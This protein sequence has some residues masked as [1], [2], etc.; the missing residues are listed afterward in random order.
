MGR[1]FA[2]NSTKLR[3]FNEFIDHM[4]LVDIPVVGNIFTWSSLDAGF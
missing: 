3:E 2:L 4:E 1:N